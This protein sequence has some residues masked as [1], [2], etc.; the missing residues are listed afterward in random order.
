M[1]QIAWLLPVEIEEERLQQREKED[2]EVSVLCVYPY[3]RP[4]VEGRLVCG[5]GSICV[6]C[7]CQRALEESRREMARVERR[8][9]QQRREEAEKV[10][11]EM[12][13][14]KAAEGFLSSSRR[15]EEALGVISAAQSL[16]EVSSLSLVYMIV[17]ISMPLSVSNGIIGTLVTWCTLC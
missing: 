8:Q 2:F 10:E 1:S 12:E 4:E 16:T 3:V 7:H 5:C 13:K 15:I 14:N 9:R 17:A 6:I 11:E